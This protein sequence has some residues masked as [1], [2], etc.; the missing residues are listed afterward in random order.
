MTVLDELIPITGNDFNNLKDTI[1][2]KHNNQGYLIYRDTYYIFQP[3][4]QNE[5]VPMYYRTTFNKDIKRFPSPLGTFSKY[6]A[7]A[8]AAPSAMAC[9]QASELNSN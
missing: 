7:T 3:N 5:D 2:D 8:S 1:I 6:A 9:R 4:N